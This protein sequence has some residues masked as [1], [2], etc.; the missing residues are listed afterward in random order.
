MVVLVCVVRFVVLGVLRMIV[1]FFGFGCFLFILWR[2]GF[3]GRM[4][5]FF[6][7]VGSWCILVV[8]VV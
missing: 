7:C 6:M 2:N 8:K 1:L 5:C 3:F 4:I